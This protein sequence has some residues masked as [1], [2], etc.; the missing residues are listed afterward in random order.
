MANIVIGR[1]LKFDAIKNIMPMIF[2]D[3]MAFISAINAKWALLIC[4]P[5]FV[6]LFS[7]SIGAG[8][9]GK[10]TIVKQMK[11]I[12]ETG[13]STEECEQYRPVVYSNTIQSLMAIIRAMGQLRI[14]FADMN[15]TVREA[16]M[17]AHTRICK[18]MTIITTEKLIC[19]SKFFAY[20]N[21]YPNY[22]RFHRKLHGNFSH[23]LQ[24]LKKVF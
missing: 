1:V 7:L 8:E 6:Y 17:H 9:S 3:I 20:S 14:D 18:H 23:M 15:K 5:L 24:L 10:S 2:A 19:R 4:V 12:H 16:F 13:Y 11:I 21:V 22:Y